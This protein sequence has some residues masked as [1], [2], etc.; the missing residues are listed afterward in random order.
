MVVSGTT[1]DSL[2]AS[3]WRSYFLLG[4]IAVED[5]VDLRDRCPAGIH[6]IHSTITLPQWLVTVASFGIYTPSELEVRCATPRLETVDD[7]ATDREAPSAP[8]EAVADE[9]AAGDV[10]V[11]ETSGGESSPPETR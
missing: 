3:E 1:P 6:S 10:P 8:G 5:E 2:R 11:A 4:L 7:V 9:E